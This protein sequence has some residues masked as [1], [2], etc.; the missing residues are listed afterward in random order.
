LF[1]F[2]RRVIKHIVVI[3]EAYYFCQN[4]IQHLPYAEEIIGDPQFGF[5]RFRSTTSYIFCI[6]QILEKEW[7]YGS[8]SVICRLQESLWF[9]LSFCFHENLRWIQMCLKETYNSVPVGKHLSETF[10]I[11]NGLKQ[12]W[13]FIAI[14]V[15]LWFWVGH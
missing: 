12:V 9:S 3:T 15:Q 2:I 13:C 14:S 1:L 8:S 10:P 4:L 5:Q 11:R 7:E 6:C